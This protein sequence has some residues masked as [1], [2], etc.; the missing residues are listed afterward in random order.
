MGYMISGSL[1]WGLLA[2]SVA[3]AA[4]KNN[5][6]ISQ[7][8]IIYD[9]ELPESLDRISTSAANI[10]QI[11][12]AFIDANAPSP[13]DSTDNYIYQTIDP[14]PSSP[15]P[16]FYTFIPEDTSAVPSPPIKFETS[17]LGP[18]PTATTPTYSKPATSAPAFCED[19]PNGVCPQSPADKNYQAVKVSQL[20][21]IYEQW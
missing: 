8:Q 21:G 16:V 13:T 14:A 15:T 10:N 7:P 17:S 3:I 20:N 6:L 12:N 11:N 19:F 4:S 5:D 2:G 1:F 9:P 18:A